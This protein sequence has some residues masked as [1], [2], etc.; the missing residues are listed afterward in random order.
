MPKIITKPIVC[1]N[2][3]RSINEINLDRFINP[4]HV[5]AI[6][7]GGARGPDTIAEHWAKRHNLE[8]ICYLPQW[9]I[10]GK[11]AG[12]IRNCEMIDFCD[13]LISFWDGTST[14]TLQ[15]IEYCQKQQKPYIKQIMKEMKLLLNVI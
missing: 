2:G 8:W 4:D 9:D 13:V 10:Y 1:I 5:A 3:S 7:T 12:M 14:G 11:R 15:A 6:V